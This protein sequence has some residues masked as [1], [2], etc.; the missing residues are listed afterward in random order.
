M[1]GTAEADGKTDNPESRPPDA[2]SL[3]LYV[4]GLVV[5]LCGILAASSALTTPDYGWMGRTILLAGLG[6]LL[7]YGARRFGLKPQ[8]L[9]F[10]FAAA[11]GLGLAAVATG[12]V[13]LEQFLPLGADNP[14]LRLMSGLVWGATVWAWALRDD[15]RVMLTT[16]P[17]MAALGLAASIDLNDPVLACFG[18]FILTVIF[19]LIH[20]NFLQNRARARSDAGQSDA[21]WPVL[22]ETT[23]RLLPAQLAQ[24]G[25]CALAVLGIG[26]VVIVPAQ[27][28]SPPPC[29]SPTTTA[30]PSAPARPTRPA[31]TS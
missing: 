14:G 25:L 6:F 12:R 7:S 26:L 9:D 23:R 4:A 28:V 27:V 2:V 22:P 8:G 15:N 11:L 24:T 1:A 10:G 19:L 3:P 30:C 13:N 29:T 20:Q 16:I 21:G 17:A 31:P 18:V 5:T